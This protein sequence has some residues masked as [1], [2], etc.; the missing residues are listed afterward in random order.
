MSLKY[1]FPVRALF[2]WMNGVVAFAYFLLSNFD[3]VPFFGYETFD[4]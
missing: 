3:I 2:L 1:I 4:D